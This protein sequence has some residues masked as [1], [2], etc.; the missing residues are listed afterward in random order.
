MEVKIQRGDVATWK[1]DGI[2][3]NLF[4]NVTT[5]GGATGAVDKALGG[6]LTKLIVQGDLKG[7]FG[8]ATIVHTL[9]RLPAARVCVVGLGKAD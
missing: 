5:P 3:V 7:K 1:G 8:N 4:E 6:L 2:V 9:D